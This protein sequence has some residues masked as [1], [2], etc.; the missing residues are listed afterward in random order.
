LKPAVLLYVWKLPTGVFPVAP[1]ETW[2]TR[3]TSL[4]STSLRS[5]PE[6]PPEKPSGSQLSLF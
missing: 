2:M 6:A 3:M 4:G 5:V 1:V